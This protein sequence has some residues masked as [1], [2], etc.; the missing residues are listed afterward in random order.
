[1][2]SAS[3]RY[4][5]VESV[6]HNSELVQILKKLYPSSQLPEKCADDKPFAPTYQVS[7]EKGSDEIPTTICSFLSSILGNR[8][9][10][11]GFQGFL[12]RNPLFRFISARKGNTEGEADCGCTLFLYSYYVY[13]WVWGYNAEYCCDEAVFDYSLKNGNLNGNEEDHHPSYIIDVKKGR[14]RILMKVALSLG[15]VVLCIGLG[16]GVMHYVERSMAGRIFASVWLLVSNLAVAR[17]FLYLAE[18]RMDKRNM[19]MAKWV[20]DQGLTVSQFLAADIDN[21]GYIVSV[22]LENYGSLNIESENRNENRWVQ[23]VLKNERHVLPSEAL[24]KVPAWS[25]IVNEKE[26]LN[27]SAGCLGLLIG[28][29]PRFD[30]CKPQFVGPRVPVLPTRIFFRAPIF[31]L[32]YGWSDHAAVKQ[33]TEKDVDEVGKIARCVIIGSLRQVMWSSSLRHFT[34]DKIKETVNRTLPKAQVQQLNNNVL[35]LLSFVKQTLCLAANQQ[36]FGCPWLQHK[37]M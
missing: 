33:H 5:L 20:L 16:V 9:K 29:L 12:H 6:L 23:E 32:E 22:V 19:R 37:L 21:N 26:E 25:T 30:P 14:M 13:D 1:I 34:G 35:V 10:K 4:C 28:K 7:N 18:A 3:G 17:A 11:I 24:M 27:V 8:D 36:P 15:V 2:P 31:T